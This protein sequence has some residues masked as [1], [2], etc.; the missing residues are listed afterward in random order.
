[1]TTRSRALASRPILISQA[2]GCTAAVIA[3]FYAVRG[4]LEFLGRADYQIKVRGVRIE[5]GEVESR[6]RE[7]PGV[8]EAVAIAW[9]NH[10]GTTEIDAQVLVSGPEVTPARLR[11]HLERVLPAAAVPARVHVAER[12]PLTPAGKID[13]R[14]LAASIPKA[15]H[16]GFVAPQ[17]PLQ[18]LVVSTIAEILGDPQVGLEDSFLA[19][20]GSSL[21]AVRAASVLG[22]R[23]GRRLRSQLFLEPRKLSEVCAELESGDA[24]PRDAAALLRLPRIGRHP[25]SARR[26]ERCTNGTSAAAVGGG[27]RSQRFLW[28]VRARRAAPRDTGKRRVPGARADARSR[29]CPASS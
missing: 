5:L 11:E 8:I 1:M 18:K 20:G 7:F 14:A 16:A 13:R 4:E 17:T 15:A 3:V 26:R 27:D 23:L 25:R 2:A 19:L 29:S 12:F 6:L 10:I 28:R 9:K 21:S 24:S 22:P